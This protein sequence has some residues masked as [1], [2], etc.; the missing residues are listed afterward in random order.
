MLT[1]MAMK[2]D[3]VAES[4]VEYDAEID[5]DY[6]HRYAEHEHESQTAGTPDPWDATER[7]W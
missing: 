4:S 5:Y 1:R 6:E 3:G 2:F 7:R